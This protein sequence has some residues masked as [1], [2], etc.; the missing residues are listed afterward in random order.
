MS[1][2]IDYPLTYLITRGDATASNFTEKKIEILDIAR[3]A[4][5]LGIS[6]VQI[7]E[8][9]LTAKLLF[10]LTLA[11][12]E[13]TLGSNTK[14][15]VNDRTDVALA[16]NAHGVHLPENGIRTDVIRQNT[17]PKFLIGTSVHSLGRAIEAGRQGA[18]FILFG[19]VFITPGK[20]NPSGLEMLREVCEA[21][22]PVPV[23]A[24]GGINGSNKDQVLEKGA[25]GFA[26][27]R[28]LNDLVSGKI[29]A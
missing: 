28:Y 19:P 10:E 26:S 6:L 1:I 13:S 22:S 17:P 2:S 3:R 14:I 12:V 15:L 21:V 25:A 23:V 27:I 29:A 11:A 5:A 8:K 20:D 4:T 18:S 16:A 9:Q 7:R 24:I